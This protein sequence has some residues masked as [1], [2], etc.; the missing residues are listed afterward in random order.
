MATRSP[1]SPQPRRRRLRRRRDG[2]RPKRPHDL[3]S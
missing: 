1:K 3:T 2:G